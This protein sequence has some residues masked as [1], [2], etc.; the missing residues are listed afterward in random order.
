MIKKQVNRGEGIGI[1]RKGA[2]L[3]LLPPV[4]KVYKLNFIYFFK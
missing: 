1:V 2:I 3:P 4:E